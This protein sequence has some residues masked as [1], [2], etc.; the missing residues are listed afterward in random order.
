MGGVNPKIFRNDFSISFGHIFNSK[1][2][3]EQKVGGARMRAAEVFNGRL[4]MLGVAGALA[5][6]IL[7]KGAW[8]EL[9]DALKGEPNTQAKKQSQEKM[10][11]NGAS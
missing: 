8:F 6:E 7:G 2:L 10:P 1:Q 11:R 9:G 5:P 4:A 3:E